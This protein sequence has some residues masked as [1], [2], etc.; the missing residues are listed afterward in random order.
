MVTQSSSSLCAVNRF[1]TLSSRRLAL[2]TVA[3]LLTAGCSNSDSSSGTASPA[4]S[5]SGTAASKLTAPVKVQLRLNWFPEAEHGGY[6]AALVHGF[7]EQQGLDVE[8]LK[9]GPG[10]PVRE[11]VGIK[12]VQFGISNADQILVARAA[13]ADIVGVLA[14]IQTSP[15]CIM[16]HEKSGIQDFAGLKNLTIA[17]NENSSFGAFLKKHAPLEGCQFV[18]YKGSLARF[19]IEDDFAQQ[20]YVFSEPFVAKK[21]GSDPHALMAADAGFNPYTSVLIVHRDTIAE[22]PELVRKFVVASQL[23]WEKYLSE[24]DAANKFIQEQNPEMEQDILAFGVKKLSTLCEVIDEQPLGSMTRERWADMSNVLV[25][26]ELIEAA[27][28]DVDAA[29][30]ARFSAAPTD[31]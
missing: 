8:I 14:P 27:K 12:R 28:V 2:L 15:R 31:E 6:Y 13:D 25:D 3:L 17:L 11:E 9:G 18:P 22:N 23:G 19:V 24:P 20:A 5:Q 4:A 16:V 10:V 1:V 29:F 30:D 21:N 7:F 26:L